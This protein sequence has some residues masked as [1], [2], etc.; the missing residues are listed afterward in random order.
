MYDMVYLLGRHFGITDIQNTFDEE[1]VRAMEVTFFLKNDNIK[2][3][4]SFEDL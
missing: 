3:C 2:S 4:S 1:T